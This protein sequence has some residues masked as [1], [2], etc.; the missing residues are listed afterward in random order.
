MLPVYKKYTAF[1]K[2]IFL[3]RCTLFACMLIVSLHL[4]SCEKVIDINLNTTVKKYVIEAVL[5]DEPNSCKVLLTQTK[6]FDENNTF[7]GVSGAQVTIQDNNEN[8]VTLSE[9]SR[10]VY[11]ATNLTGVSGHKYDLTVKVNGQTFTATSTMPALVSFDSF[12]ITERSFFGETNKYA[13]LL[14]QDP[15]GK[16]NAY[17][18]IQY[19]NG[20][21]EET[22]FVRDDNFNDGRIVERALLFFYDD[23]EEEEKKLKTGDTVTV[24]ML[25]ID[26]PVYK[27]WYSLDQ[28]STGD[29]QSATPGNP[30]TNIQ[31]GALGYF[32]AHTLRS[33]T[34]II[35]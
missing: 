6:D 24:D 13:T 31:G 19:V 1:F 21:K 25:C 11:V 5:T 20:V 30:V 16:G 23:D 12:Y 8:P 33:K 35:P 28:S 17:R 7:D 27:Y 4:T 9:T 14:Y 29:S 10:G 32:S 22:V 18:F 15:V 2:K 34:M 3:S 26:Y